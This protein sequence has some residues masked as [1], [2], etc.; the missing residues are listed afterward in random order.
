MAKENI[1]EVFAHEKS[2]GTKYHWCECNLN[3]CKGPLGI[4]T[5]K[6]YKL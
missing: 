3:V 1:F 6:I 4:A 2:I 5:Y